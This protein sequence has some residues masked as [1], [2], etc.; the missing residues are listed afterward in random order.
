MDRNGCRSPSSTKRSPFTTPTASYRQESI[1]DYTK[2]NVRRRI[3]IPDNFIRQWSAQDKKAAIRD[4]FR[5]RN[6]P[7]AMKAEAVA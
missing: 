4:L 1:V 5:E 6:R 7:E 2:E 3:C